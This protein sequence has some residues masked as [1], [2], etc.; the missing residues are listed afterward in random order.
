MLFVCSML[1][2]PSFVKR[3]SFLDIHSGR[4]RKTVSVAGADVSDRVYETT[5]S[6]LWRQNFGPYPAAEW[7]PESEYEGLWGRRSPKATGSLVSSTGKIHPLGFCNGR[8]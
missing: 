2:I 3:R 7:E 1:L 5:Y 6:R 8:I 4:Q